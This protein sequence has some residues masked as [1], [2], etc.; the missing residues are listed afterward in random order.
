MAVAMKLLHFL[1]L[2]LCSHALLLLEN[3]NFTDEL[4]LLS[5]KSMLSAGPSSLLASWNTS[6]HLCSW[7]G[8]VCG[9]GHPERVVA[10]RLDSFNLSGRIS[11]SLGNLS[12]LRELHLSNNLL[13]GKMP[14]ELGELIRLQVLNLSTNHLQGSIPV[15]MGG[16]AKLKTIDLGNNQ[17]QGEIPAEIGALNN[18]VTLRLSKNGFSGDI[19]R[20]LADLKSMEFLSLLGNKLNG[21]IPH[22]LGNLTNLYHLNLGHNMLSGGIPSSLG[23]LS[24]LSRLALGFNNLTGLIPTSLWNIS[25]LTMLSL[26]QNML[27]G[28]IPP[29]AFNTLPHLLH[30]DMDNNQF[31][32]HIPASIANASNLLLVQLGFNSFSGIIPPEVGRLQ[33]LV[34]LHIGFTLLEAKDPKGWGFISALTNC[35]NLRYLSLEESRFRGVLPDSLSNLSV[36]LEYL[37]L[38]DN[39]ISGSIPKDIGN[40]VNLQTLLLYK[41][42]FTGTLP[43]SLGRLRHMQ[44]LYLDTNTISGSIL[45]IGNLTEINYLTLD[46]NAFSGMIPSTLGNLTKLL[47]LRLSRNNFTGPIPRE[48]FNSRTL[49]I[50]LDVSENNLEGLIPQE[51]RNLKN[52]AVFRADSNKLSGEIPNTLGECQ[53][54]Q[55]LYLQNN[56]L[57][58]RVPSLLSQLKGLNYLDL[59]RNNLSEHIPEFLGNVSKLVYLNLSFNSFA[60]EIPNFGIFANSTALSIQGNDKLCGGISDLHFPPCPSKLGKRK[61]H[62]PL[63]PT[64]V[65]LAA[66]IVLLSLFCVFLSWHKTTTKH[67]STTSMQGHPLISYPQLVRATDGFSMSNLLGSGTFGT[68]FKGNI[69]TRDGQSTSLVAVKVLKLQTPG[70]LKSFTVEYETLRNIRHRNL[71]KIITT[72]SSIDNRGNDFKAIV[73]DFMPNGSLEVWL[74]PDTNDQTEKSYLNLP[75]RITILLDVAYALDYLHVHGPA[76]VVHCDLKSSNVLLDA[77]MV[78]HVGDFG[79]AKILVEESSSFHQ[80]T[81]SMGFRGT[82]GYAAPE[83]GAGNTVSTNG[84]IYSY[85]ILVLE[86][87][88]GKRPTDSLFRQESSLREYVELGLRDGVMDVVDKRL[89]SDL[90]NGLRTTNDSSHRR[91]I[92]CLV[93][94]LRLGMSCSEEVPSSRMPTGVIIKELHAI[95]ESVAGDAGHEEG[96][97]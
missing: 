80:S 71:L 50:A 94:L 62:F 92:D 10:L 5:F 15:T 44:Q 67:P 73:F 78:A 26:Q 24:R 39:A 76:P 38:H 25:S 11:P 68:V 85:G 31:H 42:S 33:N 49:S 22:Y 57:T 8:V 36:S 3:N 29:N 43:P 58:G 14:P 83:Y 9:R 95:K 1:L 19:P 64:V 96:R 86:T 91:K 6:S 59:S 20:S 79:L 55:I 13:T 17:L 84:D 77:D 70:A 93:S 18:L 63:I 4:A 28:V 65:S 89:S 48:I 61:H 40:L 2:C 35:S 12:L 82:I 74:H 21:E 81:S 53:Q 23:M 87:I 37:S 97:N 56:F 32:G 41:N 46:R 52:L 30:I 75:E 45:P 69:G 54:L 51:I 88:T 60:G 27:S 7:S 72:C 34:Q 66:T 16:C 47:E 90:E